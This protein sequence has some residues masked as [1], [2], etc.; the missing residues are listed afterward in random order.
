MNGDIFDA[1]RLGRCAL[2]HLHKRSRDPKTASPRVCRRPYPAAFDHRGTDCDRSLFRRAKELSD[3]SSC[4]DLRRTIFDHVCDAQTTLLK[5]SWQTSHKCS[6]T[7]QVFHRQRCGACKTLRRRRPGAVGSD[8][9]FELSLRLLLDSLARPQADHQSL[10]ETLA[11]Q[12]IGW[13]PRQAVAASCCMAG[14]FILCCC[15]IASAIIASA[16]SCF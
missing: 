7:G 2:S 10:A 6:P 9:T 3:R 16:S 8:S 14:D 11:Y 1:T 12:L 15:A 4:H 5:P 13:T